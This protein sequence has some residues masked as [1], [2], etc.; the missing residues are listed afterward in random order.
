MMKS[1]FKIAPIY[2]AA[3]SAWSSFKTSK[4]GY[5]YRKGVQKS[6]QRVCPTW[7]SRFAKGSQF[8]TSVQLNDERADQ[9]VWTA[10]FEKA[11]EVG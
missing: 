10:L 7:P 8:C 1:N 4:W 3:L 11:T 2:Y 9:N 5:N 6:K